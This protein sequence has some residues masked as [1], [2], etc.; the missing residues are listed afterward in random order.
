MLDLCYVE[1]MFTFK[2]SAELRTR[3]ATRIATRVATRFILCVILSLFSFVL[4]SGST[5][6]EAA[7]SPTANS[8]RA[9]SPRVKSSI[10]TSASTFKP[11]FLSL[12]FN[13][14]YMRSG[15]GRQYPAI[16]VYRRLGMPLEIVGRFD[17]WRKVR[18]FQGDTGWILSNQ[19]RGQRAVMVT[20]PEVGLYEE[21]D[22]NSIKIARLGREVVARV[23]RCDIEWCRVLI[24]KHDGWTRRGGLWGI[25]EEEL[26]P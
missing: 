11:Y 22:T 3:V 14:T 19:L 8:P 5:L 1:G 18:D 26:L 25:R 21:P 15:P 12:R 23:K 10:S 17:D 20:L 9:N 16:W 6:G 4:S 24:G 13:E 7:T 2:A